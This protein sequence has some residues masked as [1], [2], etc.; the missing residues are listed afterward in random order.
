M[1]PSILQIRLTWED[2][3]TGETRS[4]VLSLPVALGREFSQMPA[5]LEGQRVS[6]IVLD[7]AQIS[8][9]H[10]LIQP[11]EAGLVVVDQRSSNG[12]YINGVLQ[13]RSFV[14]NGD[15]IQIGPYQLTVRIVSLS[16]SANV[17]EETDPI[18][19]EDSIIGVP[20]SREVN[21]GRTVPA[22][23]LT[24]FPPPFFQQPY[25]SLRDL[26]ETRL[27]MHEFDY[28]ALGAGLGSFVWVDF[29]R[30]SGVRP[31]QIVAIGMEA[32]PYARYQRLCENSQIPS[33]ERLRS[34]SDSCPDNIWGWPSYALREAWQDAV[35]GKF[36]AALGY[37]WQVFAEPTLAQTYTPRSGRVFQSIQREAARI[38]WEQIFR[39]GRI[40]SIRKTNDGR[41]AIAYSRS[42]AEQRD[43]GFII[44]RYLH[45]AT[46]YPA[47]Q[48]LPDLKAYRET[49]QDF[50]T[51]VNAY[52]AHDH[53]Y[54]HLEQ[55]GGTVM[56]RGRGIVASR[57]VQRIYEARQTNPQIFLLH[58]MRSPKSQGNRFGHAQRTVR[59]HYE[60][61][62]FNW[63]KAC[64][65]GDLR[66]LLERSDAISRHRLLT[67]WGGTTTADRH[68][69]QHIVEQ[70][71]AQGWYKIEFG[72]V[73]QVVP[74]PS[75]QGTLTH[76]R[77]RDFKGDR[78]LEA[79]F[80]IDATGLDAKVTS[81]PLL[82]DLVQCY[83]LPLNTLGRL[84]VSNSFEVETMRSGNQGRIY[85]AGA[86]TL[87]GPYAAVDSFLGLQYAALRS[88]EE[89]VSIG[90]PN[91]RSLHP[92][93][94][95]TQWMKWAF[96]QAP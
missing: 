16:P 14:T 34:N 13:S 62:P 22:N 53:V 52:E 9:F 15:T 95:M 85:A 87:G 27:P 46:G 32:Q 91:V 75:G 86:M 68:D 50:K 21:L 79:D 48:F 71:I 11:D 73:K 30:I 76:I 44:A 37:L 93:R 40:R 70:G 24:P 63:P 47:I 18:S 7:S 64:W 56:I 74:H 60:F 65:G 1:N 72:E 43:H 10:A 78:A 31:N 66:E 23:T 39:Y 26:I 3:S 54:A 5:L 29:L 57:V 33:H 36:G 12:T 89:L 51:V 25:L 90:A 92:P 69:W 19:A 35:H 8:R 45:L 59:H 42:T 84:D 81:H 77:E 6:R 94:S 55:H 17:T 82:E 58:L 61:Q 41:F 96:N 38:G 20:E 2:P 28:A 4:P 88:V 80:I 49:T 83:Q 67:D